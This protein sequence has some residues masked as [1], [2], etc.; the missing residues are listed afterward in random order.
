LVGQSIIFCQRRFGRTPRAAR[1]R[2]A[3]AC[4]LGFYAGSAAQ[5]EGRRGAGVAIPSRSFRH[6]AFFS[7][8]LNAIAFKRR[9]ISRAARRCA[10]RTR[11]RRCAAAS[12]SPPGSAF[13]VILSALLSLLLQRRL[14]GFGRADVWRSVDIY[15]PPFCLSGVFLLLVY[16]VYIACH[17]HRTILIYLLL[18]ISYRIASCSVVLLL[19]SASLFHLSSSSVFSISL[20]WRVLSLRWWRAGEEGCSYRAAHCMLTRD[21]AVR[22]RGTFDAA[23]GAACAPGRAFAAIAS[24]IF[25]ACAAWNSS[26]RLVLYGSYRWRCTGWNVIWI[27]AERDRAVRGALARATTRCGDGFTGLR[28]LPRC[29]AAACC[30]ASFS[31]SLYLSHYRCIPSLYPIA[32]TFSVLTFGRLPS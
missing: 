2:G 8:L 16:P 17:L 3:T 20:F 26:R 14:R 6:N 32:G 11:H 29:P 10:A 12:A 4:A 21:A 1:T 23:A 27:P 13:S 19:P 18:S 28:A 15:S 24:T 9:I 31:Y 5:A 30:G 7:R 25:P 22:A